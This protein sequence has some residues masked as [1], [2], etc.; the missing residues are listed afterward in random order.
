VL[1]RV[2]EQLAAGDTGADL[3]IDQLPGFVAVDG[4]SLVA[5]VGVDN[6]GVEA[7]T[8]AARAFR[9]VLRPATWENIAGLVEPFET[10]REDHAHQYLDATGPVTWIISSDRSW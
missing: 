1:R 10:P 2:A 9:A 4:C 8:D 5:G 7:V 6:R 3:R